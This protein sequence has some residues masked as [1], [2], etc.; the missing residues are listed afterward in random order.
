MSSLKKITTVALLVVVSMITIHSFASSQTVGGLQPGFDQAIVD[1]H[2]AEAAG[3][4]SSDISDLVALLNRA[5]ELNRDALQ[6]N[7][8]ADKRTELLAQVDQLLSTVKDRAVELATS[9]GQR[10]HTGRIFSYAIGALLAILA[11]VVYGLSLAF[12]S[13]YRIRRTFQMRVRRK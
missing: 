4:P 6:T 5:L 3:A 12:Y 10:A 1:V 9:S 11:T 2:I 13:K 8:A 7:T